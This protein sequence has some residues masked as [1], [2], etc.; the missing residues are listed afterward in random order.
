[1]TQALT[2]PRRDTNGES[3]GKLSPTFKQSNRGRSIHQQ[4]ESFQNRSASNHY[5]ILEEATQYCTEKVYAQGFR[6]AAESLKAAGKHNSGEKDWK[7]CPSG[8]HHEF[9]AWTE[10]ANRRVRKPEV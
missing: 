3:S 7:R 8:S 6:W 9:E 10:A 4:S 1:M 5:G 2:T